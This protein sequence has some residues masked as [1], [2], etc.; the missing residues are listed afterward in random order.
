MLSV[1][2]GLSILPTGKLLA[3]G[4]EVEHQATKARLRPTPDKWSENEVTVAWLGHASFLINFFGTK[5][6]I[7]PALGSRI[8]LI[9]FGDQTIG[10]SR[11][12]SA[13]LKGEE[14]GPVDLLLISHAH[15]DHFDYPTLRQLQSPDTIAVTAKNTTPLWQGMKFNSLEE[16]HWGDSKSLAGVNVKAIEGKHWG[17]FKLS[18]EPMEEPITRFR[19]AA[20][21]QMEKMAIQEVGASWVLPH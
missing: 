17:T 6:I 4:E 14:V 13:A 10:P 1:A 9:P 15:T 7:D 19:Q 11:Y 21:G 20:A 8:G 12:I 3:N 5:I 2:G 18:N 16:M